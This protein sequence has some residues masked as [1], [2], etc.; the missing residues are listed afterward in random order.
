MN[1]TFRVRLG[2]GTEANKSQEDLCP[3]DVVLTDGPETTAVL[4]AAAADLEDEIRAVGGLE[5]WRA[6]TAMARF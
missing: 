2:D 5:N 4:D 3:E 6:H 1:I